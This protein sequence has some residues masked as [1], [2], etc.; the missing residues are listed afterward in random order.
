LEMLLLLYGC[1]VCLIIVFM[2][3]EHHGIKFNDQEH[4]Q[5]CRRVHQGRWNMDFFGHGVQSRQEALL[6]L[7]NLISSISG[8]IFCCATSK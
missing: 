1:D 2:F 5:D 6:H 4:Q 3:Q 7:E 8:Q